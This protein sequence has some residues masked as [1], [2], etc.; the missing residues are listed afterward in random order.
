MLIQIP[1]VDHCN[2]NCTSCTNFSPLANPTYLDI[3]QYTKGLKRLR[4]LGV[5]IDAI[6]LYGGEPLLHP[7]IAS[8]IVLPKLI[9]DDVKIFVVTNG[10]L[11]HKMTNNFWEACK[12][13][14][15][16]NISHYPPL[17]YQQVYD[18]CDKN[19]TKWYIPEKPQQMHDWK[20][21]LNGQQP[22]DPKC[23]YRTNC[24]KVLRGTRLYGCYVAAFVHHFNKA[25]SKD[26]PVSDQDSIDIMVSTKDQIEAFVNSRSLPICRYC[27]TPS[28]Q[29][30]REW[31]ESKRKIEEWA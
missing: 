23:W 13:D 26:I 22:I 6:N 12:K 27:T 30:Y 29:Y 19:K 20:L 21:D 4:E 8:I 10:L 9:F 7:D 24:G 28:Y 15:Q 25:F 31:R 14:V 2:L 11:L 18:L 1:V 3:N 16:I 5:K 17:D